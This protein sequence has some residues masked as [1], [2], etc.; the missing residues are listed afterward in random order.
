MLN[1]SFKISSHRSRFLILRTELKELQLMYA[2]LTEAVQKLLEVQQPSRTTSPTF[3]RIPLSGSRPRSNTN[4]VPSQKSPKYLTSS[5]EAIHT[6]YRTWWECAELL[7]ELGGGASAPPTSPPTSASAPALYSGPVSTDRRQTR[8]R[9]VT[10][11]GDESNPLPG[12]GSSSSVNPHDLGWRASTGRHDLSQR[13]LFLLKEMLNNPDL[14]TPRSLPIPE[15]SPLNRQWRWGDAT[16][17]T[18]TIPSDAGQATSSNQER[19]SSR[20]GIGGLRDMLKFLKR[21]H[22]EILTPTHL[23]SSVD[24]DPSVDHRS[25]HHNHPHIPT[26]RRAKSSTGPESVKSVREQRPTSPFNEISLKPK[27]S[28]RRPSLASI[29]RLGQKSKPVNAAATSSG[30]Q[31]MDTTPSVT[32]TMSQSSDPNG[33]S[34]HHAEDEDWDQMDSTSDLNVADGFEADEACPITPS[35]ALNPKDG[36]FSL[37]EERSSVPPT[38]LTPL[39]NVEEGMDVDGESSRVWRLGR[40]PSK[41]KSRP[42]WGEGFARGGATSPTRFASQQHIMESR[43]EEIDPNTKPLPNARLAMTPENIRPLLGNAREVLSRLRSCNGEIR[44]LLAT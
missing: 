28:P 25:H 24:T 23:S 6:K 18:V 17:S 36:Q 19:R 14:S 40:A 2:S 33:S 39:S 29:F 32:A 22:T 41:P 34:S 8:G 31:S 44:L 26:Q 30:D 38:R 37:G 20:L 7:I 27:N 15:E 12:F 5:L 35:M 9:A 4:P 43:S 11:T 1:V 21:H 16:S 42:I 3:F 13:Q 10:L